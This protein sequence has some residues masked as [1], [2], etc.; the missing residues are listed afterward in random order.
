MARR[1]TLESERGQV[2]KSIE[3]FEKA[4]LAFEKIKSLT[5]EYNQLGDGKWNHLMNY[6]PRNLKALKKPVLG[7]GLVADAGSKRIYYAS[8]K[9]QYED[10]MRIPDVIVTLKDAHKILK[11]DGR[12]HIVVEE[13]LSID[14]YGAYLMPHRAESYTDVDKAP[15]LQF[16]IDLKPGIYRARVKFLP[17]RPT[18]KNHDM[19][20][21]FS[22]DGGEYVIQ[23]VEEP[24]ETFHNH[25]SCQWTTT[26]VSESCLDGYISQDYELIS[27]GEITIQI[28]MLD[29]GMVFH[30][31]E[32]FEEVE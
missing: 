2:D 20:C 10:L 16:T 13:G 9:E 7:S 3:T 4:E 15:S 11:G 22:V 17:S 27:D 31:I 5:E 24:K 8:T 32:I 21:A 30:R 12:T 25:H 1:S 19:C 28:K 29:T 26:L 6:K 14:S 23:N 18:T